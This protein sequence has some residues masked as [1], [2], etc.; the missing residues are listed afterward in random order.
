M[1]FV[2]I[3]EVFVKIKATVCFN[4]LP[5]TFFHWFSQLTHPKHSKNI[6]PNSTK[7]IHIKN[8]PPEQP[9]PDKCSSNETDFQIEYVFLHV[10]KR[11]KKL[12]HFPFLQ[13]QNSLNS[14]KIYRRI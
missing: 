4:F 14:G 10:V 11:E 13:L 8:L 1:E 5:L 3:E 6:R 9:K 7:R 12:F 2:T